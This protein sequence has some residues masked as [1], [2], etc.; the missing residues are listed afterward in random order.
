MEPPEFPVKDYSKSI[1]L[2]EEIVSDFPDYK[3]VDGALYMLGYCYSEANSK[4]LDDDKAVAALPR[5]VQEYPESDATVDAS[6]RL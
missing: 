6:L 1:D 5:L 2:Y 3:F 4:Q